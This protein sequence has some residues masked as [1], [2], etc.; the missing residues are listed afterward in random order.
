KASARRQLANAS[1]PISNLSAI[2]DPLRGLTYEVPDLERGKRNINARRET[3]RSRSGGPRRGRERS[4]RD[5]EPS[6]A[7]RAIVFGLATAIPVYLAFRSDGYDIFV[8][9][10]FGLVLWWSLALGFAFGILP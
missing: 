1:L 8:R 7:E 3:G 9:Q 10:E 6:W 4:R 2:I 5:R